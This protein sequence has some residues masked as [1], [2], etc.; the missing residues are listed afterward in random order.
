MRLTNSLP[1]VIQS[2][3][4]T[5]I[6][7]LSSGFAGLLNSSE[8]HH[9]ASKDLMSGLM[10]D[11]NDYR[12]G[13]SSVG[14]TVEISDAYRQRTQDLPD[15]NLLA[16]AESTVASINEA[17]VTYSASARLVKASSAMVDALFDAIA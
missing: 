11:Q 16:S 17:G 1:Q 12:N 4:Q 15:R 14:V 6:G 13:A 10:S 7:A 3:A 2:W 8:Q 5:S 9:Q